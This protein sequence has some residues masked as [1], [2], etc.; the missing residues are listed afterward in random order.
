MHITYGCMYIHICT[1]GCHV[2][3]YSVIHRNIC[4]IEIERDIYIYMYTAHCSLLELT[5]CVI[6]PSTRPRVTCNSE[7]I[8]CHCL[9]GVMYLH[10]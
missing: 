1:Y 8:A 2:Y 7:T 9:P 5:K 3:V 4:I 6:E 10:V